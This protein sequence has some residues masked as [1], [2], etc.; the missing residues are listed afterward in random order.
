[1]DNGAKLNKKMKVLVVKEKR[2]SVSA[3]RGLKEVMIFMC[4]SR[5]L[6]AG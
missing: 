3:S 6:K 2:K 1:M 5:P 4:S